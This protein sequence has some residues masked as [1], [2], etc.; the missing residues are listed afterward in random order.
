MSLSDIAAGLKG[1]FFGR[2]KTEEPVSS[3]KEIREIGY[4]P[5][6]SDGDYKDRCVLVGVVRSRYQFERLM[7]KR[8]YHI[9]LRQVTEC[10][11]P[12]KYIAIYQSKRFFGKN[13]GIRYFGEVEGCETVKR[14][15]IR[16]IPKDS[17]EKYLYFKIKKWRVL[18]KRIE[19][20]EMENTAF[21]TTPYLLKN[22]KDSAEL[23][24]RSREEHL[25][26]KKLIQRVNDLV[27]MRKP[28][29][30]DIVFKDYTLKLRG[31]MVHLF[32]S[33][34]LQYAVGYDVFL[35][36]PADLIR[37]IFDYYPEL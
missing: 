34:I 7:R 10:F 17:D 37:D 22:G 16:E 31:G 26:Y 33:E 6:C 13:A 18:S 9:P 11:F 4:V 25:L 5:E 21:S 14:R 30:D 29:G 28:N 2:S 24:L 23:T 27:R 8:F 32:F 36:R 12:V 19:A 15:D 1:I 20:K 3:D 35:E